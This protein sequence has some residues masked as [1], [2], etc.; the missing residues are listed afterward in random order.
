MDLLEDKIKRVD[1][2]VCFAN[3]TGGHDFEAAKEFIKQRFLE[4]NTTS[5]TIYVH[6][7]CAINTDNI[8][9]VFASVRK[10]LLDEVLGNL[11]SV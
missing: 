9:V 2:N 8:E 7:T 5:R 1:L 6:Y 10:T 4:Q 11:F 3:Y